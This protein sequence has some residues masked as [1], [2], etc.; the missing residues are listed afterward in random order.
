MTLA[1]VGYH[2][3][4]PLPASIP[5]TQRYIAP[6]IYERWS[7]MYVRCNRWQ[8]WWTHNG[9]TYYTGKC[10]VEWGLESM[11]FIRSPRRVDIHMDSW[12]YG[13]SV[14]IIQHGYHVLPISRCMRGIL[15]RSK[16]LVGAP[17][18]EIIYFYL[19]IFYLLVYYLFIHL[20][21]NYR[22]MKFPLKR[23][24]NSC[25]GVPVSYSQ[26]SVSAKCAAKGGVNMVLICAIW[27]YRYE[28]YKRTERSWTACVL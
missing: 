16:S 14:W 28:D 5:L 27:N 13:Y 4:A 19:M 12:Q 1:L 2:A 15:H 17:F 25:K 7:A 26:V 18:F 23:Q 10:D 3:G 9:V 21:M 6:V 24:S 8:K 20:F 22:P 11:E